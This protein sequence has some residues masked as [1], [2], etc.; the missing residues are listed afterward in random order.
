MSGVA[1]IFMKSDLYNL[2]YK[3]SKFILEINYIFFA[4]ILLSCILF[5]LQLMEI[6][7]PLYVL[8]KF[9]GIRKALKTNSE[10]FSFSYKYLKC[11]LS[12]GFQS[13]L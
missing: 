9:R 10:C 1:M 13:K 12:T 4:F 3:Y 11:F 5:Y 2:N 8:A 6:L 7:C